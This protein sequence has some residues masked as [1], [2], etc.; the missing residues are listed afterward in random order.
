MRATLMTCLGFNVCAAFYLLV[1]QPRTDA[2][3]AFGPWRQ[4]AVRVQQHAD[5][6]QRQT[7]RE[8]LVIADG[9]YRLASVLAFYR[10]PLELDVDASRNTTSRWILGGALL[11]CVVMA[12][13]VMIMIGIAA[14][15]DWF[16]AEQSPSSLQVLQAICHCRWS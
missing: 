15:M 11:Q 7:G 10:Q 9:K 2:L 16:N 5:E 1:V 4:L 13:G 12:V 14:L 8:P 6:L 3:E